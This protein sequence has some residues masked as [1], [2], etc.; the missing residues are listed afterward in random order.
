[1]C[2]CCGRLCFFNITFT[3]LYVSKYFSNTHY[4]PAVTHE[5]CWILH[6][7]RGHCE[8]RRLDDGPKLF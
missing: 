6:D 5:A 8:D 7:F 3:V 1:V 2:V 4:S